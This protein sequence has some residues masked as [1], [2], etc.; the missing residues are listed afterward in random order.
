MGFLSLGT[1]FSVVLAQ[2]IL[3]Y[4]KY[5]F[6]ISLLMNLHLTKLG[7]SL[8]NSN[9]MVDIGIKMTSVLLVAL[10]NTNCVSFT[11]KNPCI[12]HS[13]SVLRGIYPDSLT[14]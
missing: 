10:I 5:M 14:P 3:A 2:W 4:Y 7:L 9:S 11:H 12:L 13:G 6:I 1:V 8:N